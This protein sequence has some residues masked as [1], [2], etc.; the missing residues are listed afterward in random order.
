MS[1]SFKYNQLRFKIFGIVQVMVY[2]YKTEFHKLRNIKNLYLS[3][4]LS[5]FYFLF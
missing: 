5:L 2:L 1:L 4:T 3:K